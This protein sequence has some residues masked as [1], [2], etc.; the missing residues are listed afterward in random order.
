MVVN[1]LLFGMILQVGGYKVGP[2]SSYKW[3]EI[4]P[5]KIR[6]ISPQA[7]TQLFIRPFK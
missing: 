3:V 6:V 5:K 4:T 7:V 2:G 1:H